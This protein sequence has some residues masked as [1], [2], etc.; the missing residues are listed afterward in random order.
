MICC[1]IERYAAQKNQPINISTQEIETFLANVILT[2][3]NSRPR[4]CLYWS[5]NDNVTCSLV[6][7]NMARKRFEDIKRYLHFVDNNHLQIGE[8]LAKTRLLQ[9]RINHFLQQFGV[10]SKDLSID[11]QM[12]PHFGRHSFKMFIRGKPIRFGYKNWVLASSYGYPYKF[13][14]CTGASKSK[15]SSKPLGPQV[16]CSLLSVVKN[17]T[18]YHV[19]FDNFLSFFLL[20][21]FFASLLA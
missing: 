21:L 8:K 19:Y 4:Q 12:V 17:P 5:K 6:S 18:C 3:Y 1:E 20:L 11:E 14:T 16:V 15:D 2:G 7:R 10:F 13:E 9:D